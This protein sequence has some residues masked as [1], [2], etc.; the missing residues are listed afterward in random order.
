MPNTLFSHVTCTGWFERALFSFV[1]DG[2]DIIWEENVFNVVNPI[3]CSDNPSY[4]NVQL[5]CIKF[6]K[7]DCTQISMHTNA[8]TVSAKYNKDW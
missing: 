3:D 8:C 4:A 7:V 5:M 1:D 6:T 2:T